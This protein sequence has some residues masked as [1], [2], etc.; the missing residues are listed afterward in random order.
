MNSKE[1]LL[2]AAGY[3]SPEDKKARLDKLEESLMGLSDGE[4]KGSPEKRREHDY[5]VKVDCRTVRTISKIT[6][7]GGKDKW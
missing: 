1:K 5:V 4:I 6:P 7:G 2:A 3:E